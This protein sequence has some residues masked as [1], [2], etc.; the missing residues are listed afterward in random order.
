MGTVLGSLQGG[1]ESRDD[2]NNCN[3]IVATL[4]NIKGNNGGA[5][6]R[7]GG[8]EAACHTFGIRHPHNMNWPY[9]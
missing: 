6:K 2:V 9:V 8:G 4:E 3:D 5:S 1:G 7:N